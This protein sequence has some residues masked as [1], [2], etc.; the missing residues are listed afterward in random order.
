MISYEITR[1]KKQ[2]TPTPIRHI[3]EVV[4]AARG[5]FTVDEQGVVHTAAT[6]LNAE[7]LE[8][9]RRLAEG[10]Q[11]LPR[12][13]QQQPHREPVWVPMAQLAKQEREKS[14]S[15]E[16]GSALTMGKHGYNSWMNG[17][18]YNRFN[19][20]TYVTLRSEPIVI[21]RAPRVWWRVVELQEIHYMAMIDRESREPKAVGVNKPGG[22]WTGPTWYPPCKLRVLQPEELKHILGELTGDLIRNQEGDSEA[23]VLYSSPSI[24]PADDPSTGRD[25][26]EKEH[27]EEGDI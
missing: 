27:S 22:D 24:G 5:I 17:F 20:G 19:K 3:R 4:A 9:Q 11:P 15:E 12:A 16:A 1:E 14:I 7:R 10:L 21:T 2:A 18:V 6:P 23:V 25:P 8:N 26:F 13:L